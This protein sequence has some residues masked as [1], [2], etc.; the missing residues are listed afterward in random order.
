MTMTHFNGSASGDRIVVRADTE[1]EDLIPA[2]LDNRKQDVTS[3]VK[4]LQSGNFDAIQRL[5]H[6]MKGTGAGYG[7]DGITQIGAAL[8]GHAR[9]KDMMGIVRDIRELETYLR[10]VEVVYD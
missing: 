2:F 9:K 5:G 6:N 4:A 10:R 8:E 7:F 1:I 3:M